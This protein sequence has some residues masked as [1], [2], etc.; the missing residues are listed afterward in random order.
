MKM[1]TKTKKGINLE[2][3]ALTTMSYGFAGS[4]LPNE[5][6]ALAGA[7]IG[8]IVSTYD[9]LTNNKMNLAV[10]AIAGIVGTIIGSAFNVPEFNERVQ[11]LIIYTG[12]ITGYGLGAYNSYMAKK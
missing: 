7:G 3:I 1:E 11:D 10:P 5:N 8:L 6:S 9:E 2:R 12:A 4:F